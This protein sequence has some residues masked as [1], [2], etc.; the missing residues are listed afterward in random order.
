MQ[1]NPFIVITS[2]ANDKVVDRISERAELQ[3]AINELLHDTEGLKLIVIHGA[4]GVGKSTIVNWVTSDLEKKGDLSIIKEEF[5][6]T[7]FNKLKTFNIV[8]GKKMIIILD[9][10]NN[11]DLLDRQTQ[12]KLIDLIITLS[13]TTV[14]ILV[15]NREQGVHKQLLRLGQGF[16]EMRVEPLDKNDVLKI[17]EDRLNLIRPVPSSDI[18]PFTEEEIDKVYHKSGGN[19]RII[20]LI[21]ST[22]FDRKQEIEF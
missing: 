19:P 16:K 18:A 9:D 20:L 13:R 22:L 4:P 7:V 6:L 3:L 12:S 11:L 15:D 10:F 2:T 1:N 5:N 14:V 8:E 17:I 21:L